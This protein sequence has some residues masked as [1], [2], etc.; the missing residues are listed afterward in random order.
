[1]TK[2][3]AH[4]GGAALWPENTMRAFRG[5]VAL[6]VDAIE[7]DVH[8]SADGVPMVIHDPTLARTGLGDGV[9][10]ERLAASFAEGPPDIDVDLRA[11]RL[12]AVLALLAPTSLDVSVELKVDRLDRRYPALCEQVVEALS[13]ADMMARAFVHTFDWG[14]LGELQALAPELDLGANVEEQTLARFAG[15]DAMLDAIAALEVRDLN[16]DHHLIDDHVLV[17]ARERG[18]GITLWTVNDDD[19]IRRFLDAGIDNLCTDRPD[20]ALELRAAR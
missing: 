11:P 3:V 5:A 15:W 9:V 19:A 10:V 18:L 2:I 17:Q 7:L 16:A 12:Q 1:M 4:R 6:G 14:S 13:S 8:P 20:R